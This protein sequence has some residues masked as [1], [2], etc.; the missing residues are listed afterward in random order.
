MIYTDEM[1]RDI[2]SGKVVGDFYPYDM[3]KYSEAHI[4]PYIKQVRESL[5]K[6]R[7]IDLT[8][9][10]SSYGSGFASFV[11]IFCWKKDGSSTEERK[12]YKR[13]QGIRIYI[14]RLAPVAVYGA[15]EIFVHETGGGFD[16]LE[17][18]KV[19]TT[20]PGDWSEVVREITLKLNGF[21]YLLLDRKYVS[22][23]LTIEVEIPTIL[24]GDRY[25]VMDAFFYWED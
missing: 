5:K 14:C 3:G 12:E 8:A 23:D 16:F 7:L 19:G 18:R 11:D 24:S 22:K 6:S 4:D 9:D 20:P 1:L 10:F 25:K 21:G 13:I 2:I 15:A 17:P